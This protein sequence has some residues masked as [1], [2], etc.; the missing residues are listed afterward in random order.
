MNS[1]TQRQGFLSLRLSVMSDAGSASLSAAGGRCQ[2]VSASV[3]RSKKRGML[4]SSREDCFLR[5][6][7]MRAHNRVHRSVKNNN[8]Y[9]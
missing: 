4:K 2:Q 5:A 3:G 1:D 9:L 6:S 7:R 8:V